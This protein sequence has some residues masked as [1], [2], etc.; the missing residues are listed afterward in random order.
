MPDW[1]A[2]EDAATAQ[3]TAAVRRVR[4]ERPDDHI[5]GA[6][7]HEFYGD[8]SVIYWPCLT[9]GTEEGLAQV[10]ASY[11]EHS[12]P[13]ESGEREQTLRWSGPDLMSAADPLYANEPGE[14]E[15]SL[16][17][18]VHTE[19]D[20]RGFE[21]WEKVY[22]RFLRV[23]PKAAKRARKELLADGTVDR[24][25]IAI[26][27]DEAGELIPLSLTKAQ[28]LKHFPQY[29]A[30]EQERRR[31]AALPVEQRVAELL[32]LGLRLSYDGPLPGE[33]PEL[34]AACGEAAVPAL[35]RTVQGIEFPDSPGVRTNA[36]MLLAEINHDDPAVIDA[37]EALMCEPTAAISARAWAAA[38]LARLDRTDLIGIHLPEL[39]SEVAA[40]G[41]AAPF[42]SFRDHGNHR[43]L[44]Y[45]PL[46]A[47]L[48]DHPD[49]VV[50]VAEEL[51]PGVGFCTIDPSEADAARVG[52]T[53]G[54][55]FIRKH[56][57]SVLDELEGA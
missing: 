26:A 31:L 8:G 53:S 49:I 10:V 24:E 3:L 23:F 39:P 50:E 16:A 17:K 14:V 44:D 34:L 1:K 25:F 7:F 37:L 47:V 29:D 52:L 57:R 15:N 9:V 33:Y 4:A 28:L 43:P 38:A 19:A 41:L 2:V 46:E 40:R 18:Q 30:A 54:W 36:A 55:T 42:R 51:R 22:E 27:E 56:A 12:G 35:V 48:M 32:P 45:A 11:E 20:G 5:Y 21:A 6:M 13:D